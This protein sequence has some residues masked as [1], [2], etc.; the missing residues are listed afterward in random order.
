M[1]SSVLARIPGF[2][3]RII[4]EPH[5]FLPE[6]HRIGERNCEVIYRTKGYSHNAVR[7]GAREG[8]HVCVGRGGGVSI[9]SWPIIL[10]AR[11]HVKDRKEKTKEIE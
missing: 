6:D 3:Q 4:Q 11:K 10:P 5:A 9:A 8:V 7:G 2:R 1:R